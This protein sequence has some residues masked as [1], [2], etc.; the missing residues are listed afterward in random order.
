MSRKK[1]I[2]APPAPEWSFPVDTEK[3]SAA[4]LRISIHP[5][6]EAR[7]LLAPRLGIKALKSLTADITLVRQPGQATIHVSGELE[8]AV[9][10]ECVVSGQPVEGK[11]KEKFEA[12]YGDQ[13]KTVSIVKARYDKTLN[14]GNAEMPILEEYEDPE[15]IIEGKIDAGELVA[16]YLSLAINPYPHAEG[17]HFEVGDEDEKAVPARMDNPFAA[18]KGWKGKKG[19]PE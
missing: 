4:P 6:A 12:W 9:T 7:K 1:S 11:I 8:A 16:Q 2:P 15:P 5:N 10:Q 19:K 17:V 13:E 14:K 3:V 18:L